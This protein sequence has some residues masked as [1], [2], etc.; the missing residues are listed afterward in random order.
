MARYV[1]DTHAL[2]WHLQASRKLSK[3]AREIFEQT[4]AGRVTVIIPSIVLVEL[5]YLAEKDRIKQALVDHVF[6]LLATGAENYAVTPLEADTVQNLRGIAR[7]QV[8]EMP[9]RIVAATAKQLDLPL[10]TRDPAIRAAK[11]LTTI[12]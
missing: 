10:I 11:G 2:I 5:V 7:S 6:A 9:D 12:W 4:D 8:P 1:T 3:R